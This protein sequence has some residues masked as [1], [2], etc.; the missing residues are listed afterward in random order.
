V[1]LVHSL[2]IERDLQA[3]LERLGRLTPQHQARWGKMNAPQMVAHLIDWK[4][5]ALG[6]LPCKPKKVPLRY[7]PIKQL[8]VYWLPWPKGVPT[9]RELLSGKPASWD[10]DVA[11]LRALV[12]RLARRDRDAPWPRHPG[13]GTLSR[14][15]WGVLT[16]RHMD[17][18]LRQFGV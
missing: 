13:F 4:R 12:E 9:A 3:L 16:Y 11:E 2:W 18:H 6:D 7:P 5:M 17:H 15:A 10:A 14:R 8:V 1:S